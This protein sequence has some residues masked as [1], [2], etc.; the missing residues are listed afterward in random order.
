MLPPQA[1]LSHLCRCHRDKAPPPV[2]DCLWHRGR[3]VWLHCEPAACPSPPPLWTEEQRSGTRGH[4]SLRDAFNQ[5]L[6]IHWKVDGHR[7]Q[8]KNNL[9]FHP[10]Q[11]RVKLLVTIQ[12]VHFLCECEGV[13]SGGCWPPPR[14]LQCIH[15]EWSCSQE[16]RRQWP[17]WKSW[18]S[19]CWGPPLVPLEGPETWTALKKPQERRDGEG[20]TMKY[21]DMRMR[22]KEEGRRWNIPCRAISAASSR[23]S[24]STSKPA[25]LN[26]TSLA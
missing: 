22:I 10:R 20:D 14:P 6:H 3:P 21:Q 17:T 25:A 4:A 9:C 18:R 19:A 15:S 8:N 11:R 24:R 23:N 7:L 16:H 26:S 13:L 2:S 5:L 1:W 12:T